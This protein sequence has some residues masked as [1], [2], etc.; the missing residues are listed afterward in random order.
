M[1]IL[2]KFSG[3]LSERLFPRC[4]HYGSGLATSVGHCRAAAFDFGIIGQS[5]AMTRSNLTRM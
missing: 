4:G 5:V 2:N 3:R 1:I